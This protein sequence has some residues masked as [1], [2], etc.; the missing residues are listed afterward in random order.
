M[1]EMQ[2]T[3]PVL[4]IV[5]P[6]LAAVAI[7]GAGLGYAVH[8]HHAAERLAAQNQ[9][10][11]TEL[12]ST[13]TQ[14][15]DLTAKVSELAARS[16]VQAA[17]PPAPTPTVA[18]LASHPAGKPHAGRVP[19]RRL[20]KMQAQLDAQGKAIE[21]TRGDLA[22]ARTELTGSIAKT[23]DELVV[24]EKKGE[25]SY[26]EFDI[27]KSKAFTHEGP[28]GVSLRKANLKHQYADLELMVED[29][30][31]VQKHVNLD[32]PV[33]FYQPDTELPIQVVINDIT[34]DRIHGYVSAPKYRKSELASTAN[35][36]DGIVGDPAQAT[37]PDGQTAA[38]KKLTVPPQD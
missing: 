11:T 3:S 31:L 23:H 30:D 25:R 6:I 13:R 15:N 18:T 22:S 37:S 26:F 19:D 32:Q 38:R 21:A 17:Q 4:K 9:Q 2:T 34:K 12:A 7:G 10:M 29:R 35:P 14:M 24:L 27:Q 36:D 5:A 33:M 1:E 28:V 16:D 20:T 8:E